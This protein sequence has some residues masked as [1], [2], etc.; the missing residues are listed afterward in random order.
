MA[1]P[2]HG[3]AKLA[4][5]VGV[6][7]KSPAAPRLRLHDAYVLHLR[8]IEDGNLPTMALVQRWQALRA[9]LSVPSY[10]GLTDVDVSKAISEVVSLFD[11]ACRRM[12]P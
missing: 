5:A 8:H 4:Q 11:G 12:P 9:Q 10:A 3:W 7:A 6:L 2:S 1:D